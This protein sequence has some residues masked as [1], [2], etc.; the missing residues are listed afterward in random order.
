L[1]GEKDQERKRIGERKRM[2]EN[3]ENQQKIPVRRCC[4]QPFSSVLVEIWRRRFGLV[5]SSE[6]IES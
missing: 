5:S 1:R 3:L 6:C 2:G 4:Q